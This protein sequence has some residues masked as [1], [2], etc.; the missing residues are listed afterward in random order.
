[1]PAPIVTCPNCKRELEYDSTNPFRP[2]CSKRCQ[3]L[4]LEAW[5]S[6]RYRVATS[7]DASQNNAPVDD[8]EDY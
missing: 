1:M 2:F 7:E 8:D 5:A 6:E 3:S 4:D